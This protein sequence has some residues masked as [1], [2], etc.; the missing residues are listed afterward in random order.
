MAKQTDI[1][2][3]TSRLFDKPKNEWPI[4]FMNE[5]NILLWNLSR[6]LEKRENKSH[7]PINLY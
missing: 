1:C 5:V 6:M 4:N 7:H 3:Q 2:T